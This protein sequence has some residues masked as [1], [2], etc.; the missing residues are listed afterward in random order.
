MSKFEY[1]YLHGRLEGVRLSI[2]QLEQVLTA[3]N[4]GILEKGGIGWYAD[5]VCEKGCINQIAFNIPFRGKSF[6]KN[7]ALACWFDK[8]YQ[9]SWTTE[10]FLEALRNVGAVEPGL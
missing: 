1:V 9:S 5:T 3:H 8:N 7:P 4:L 6:H 2:K 10:E